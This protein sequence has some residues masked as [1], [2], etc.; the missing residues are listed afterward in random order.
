MYVKGIPVLLNGLN[1]TKY[2]IV[3]F[4]KNIFRTFINL[5]YFFGYEEIVKELLFSSYDENIV[6][7]QND[8]I[9]ARFDFILD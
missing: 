1:T 7:G 6:M 5:F 2:G 8:H 3:Y 9:F 4:R